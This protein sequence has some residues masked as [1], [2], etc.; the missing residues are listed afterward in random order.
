MRVRGLPRFPSCRGS[1]GKRSNL[2]KLQ[3][4]ER[5]NLRR[6]PCIEGGLT[7]CWESFSFS[8]MAFLN[9][10]KKKKKKLWCCGGWLLC[11]ETP[12]TAH[13]SSC[14]HQVCVVSGGDEKRAEISAQTENMYTKWQQS[15]V[16]YRYMGW[17]LQQTKREFPL[18]KI[19]QKLALL[20]NISNCIWRTR[21][22]ILITKMKK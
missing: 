5:E 3:L 17:M 6:I 2:A 16:I 7:V 10:L 8:R 15:G 21:G 20:V 1:T 9:D 13:R 14:V 4:I 11:V 12:T 22:D 18:G 19:N